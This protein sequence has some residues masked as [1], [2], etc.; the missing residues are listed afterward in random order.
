MDEFR[1]FENKVLRQAGERIESNRGSERI[2]HSE[3]LLFV[4][5]T[6]LNRERSVECDV[7]HI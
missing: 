7:Q 2:T 5:F 4:L 6:C 3:G 1:E